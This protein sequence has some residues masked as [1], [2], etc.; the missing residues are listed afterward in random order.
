MSI[1]PSPF[2]NFT[3]GHAVMKSPQVSEN[4]FVLMTGSA[5]RC[6]STTMGRNFDQSADSS[7]GMA[8]SHLHS[9]KMRWWRSPSLV[10]SVS[11]IAC[12]TEGAEDTSNL[13]GAW[14]GQ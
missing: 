6:H 10:G 4:S 13:G 5:L 9:S 8:L 7:S 11:A 14:G 1:A 2:G 3:F 12:N